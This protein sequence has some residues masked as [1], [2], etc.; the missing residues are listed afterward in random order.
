MHSIKSSRPVLL[1]LFLASLLI[2]GL[3][4]L[5]VI[6]AEVNLLADE[7]GYFRRAVSL[8]NALRDL[9]E[10]SVPQTETL[11]DAYAGGVHPPLNSILLTLPLFLFGTSTAVARATIVLISALT[12][13]LV[14]SLARRLT[15]RTSALAAGAAHLLFPSF[16]AYS[17]YLWSETAYVF[18]GLLGLFFTVSLL[19]SQSTGRAVRN[20]LLTGCCLG[21]MG[22]ARAA[23]IPILIIVPVWI[24]ISQKR[25]SDKIAYPLLVLVSAF[26]VLLPWLAALTYF[27]ERVVPLSTAAEYNLFLG[28]NP[29]EESGEFEID[30]KDEVNKAIRDYA[31]VHSLGRATAARRLALSEIKEHPGT[32]LWRCFQKFRIIW[33]PDRF[34]LRHILHVVYPPMSETAVISILMV[35]VATSVVFVGLGWWVLLGAGTDLRH[36]GLLIVFVVAAM[37]PAL[38]TVADTRFGF[39]L[40]AFML[41]AVGLG[42]KTLITRKTGGLVTISLLLG[43]MSL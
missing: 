13:P 37:A 31:R 43:L 38:I 30:A 20:A 8:E 10:G 24:S 11:R 4:L 33:L 23:S 6:G 3:L 39:P 40:L 42:A 2:R 28:N 19:E 18:F 17:H 16:L 26:A 35:L 15:C 7:T 1:A 22:L 34:I 29:W 25:I 27:E 5:P 21:F 41:P 14:Y 12:T 36:R 9:A 32:F